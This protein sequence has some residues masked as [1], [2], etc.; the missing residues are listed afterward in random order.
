[1]SGRHPP[2]ISAQTEQRRPYLVRTHSDQAGSWARPHGFYRCDN[3]CSGDHAPGLQHAISSTGNYMYHMPL[4]YKLCILATQ[5]IC[6]FHMVL[7]NRQR[8]FP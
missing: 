1:M 4:H 2:G 7:T 5:C 3:L 8:L 6:V